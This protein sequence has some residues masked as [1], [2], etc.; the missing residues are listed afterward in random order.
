MVVS[1]INERVNT[2]CNKKKSASDIFYFELRNVVLIISAFWL[3]R[4]MVVV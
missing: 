2:T 4:F 1:K 3:V